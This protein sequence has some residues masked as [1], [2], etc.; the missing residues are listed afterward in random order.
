MNFNANCKTF[1]V[2]AFF[3]ILHFY[4]FCG[5]LSDTIAPLRVGVQQDT[6]LFKRCIKQ[7]QDLCPIL[8]EVLNDCFNHSNYWKIQQ[9]KPFSYFLFQNPT[10][11]FSRKEELLKIE[12]RIE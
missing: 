10:Q 9:F 5:S 6:I 12:S 4:S 7:I 8:V 3:A 2:A 1:V 11:W